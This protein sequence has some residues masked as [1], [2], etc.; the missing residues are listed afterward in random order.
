MKAHAE[1]A[2]SDEQLAKAID[3]WGDGAG[4]VETKEAYWIREI[5]ES[6]S[7]SIPAP[8]LNPSGLILTSLLCSFSEHFPTESAA[9]TAVRFVSSLLASMPREIDHRFPRLQMD[10]KSRLGH[11]RRP[12]RSSRQN[13]RC[14][15]LE[16]RSYSGIG[17]EGREGLD[18]SALLQLVRPAWR[19]IRHPAPLSTT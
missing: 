16:Q 13:S 10:P 15:L 5:F 12:V 7:P 14:C 19:V 3:R 1:A 4:K 17:S 8:P 18:A 9:S 11:G 2:V 6:T